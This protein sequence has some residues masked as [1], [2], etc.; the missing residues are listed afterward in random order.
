MLPSTSPNEALL[1]CAPCPPWNLPSFT[2]S[3]PFP[4]HALALISLSSTMV[5]LSPPLTLSPVTIWYSGL[6]A[7]FLFYLAEAALAYFPT[8]FSVAL[9]P[10]FP[11]RQAQYVEVNPMKPAPFCTLFAGLGNTNKSAIFFSSLLLLSDS[12]F[13]LTTLSSPPSFLPFQAL[14]QIWQKLFSISSCSIWL[15]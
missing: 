12:R 15:Q 4:F 2:A 13:V 6:T 5:R 7:L 3:P 1:V 9:R 10:L 8:A 14:W 11:C